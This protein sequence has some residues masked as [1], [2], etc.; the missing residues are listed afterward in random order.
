MFAI[1][2]HATNEG[3]YKYG[4]TSTFDAHKC[5]YTDD[6]DMVNSDPQNGCWPQNGVT[7]VTACANGNVDGWKAWCK[8][9][10]KHCIDDVLWGYF[11]DVNHVLKSDK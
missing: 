7:N 8:T 5:V 6:C 2:I 3:S 1:T 9:D 10:V 4:F 11:P